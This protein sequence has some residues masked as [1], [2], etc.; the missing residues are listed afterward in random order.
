MLGH[1]STGNKLQLKYNYGL[2]V[3]IKKFWFICSVTVSKADNEIV[4]LGY[5][6]NFRKPLYDLYK[7]EEF[8]GV[9]NH[10]LSQF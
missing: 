5:T 4:A 10:C 9:I 8:T 3:T 7:D 1:T 6:K 2:Q